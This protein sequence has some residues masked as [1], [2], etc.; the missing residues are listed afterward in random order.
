MK[1]KMTKVSLV[2]TGALLS[3]SV[4]SQDFKKV[5]SEPTKL[6]AAVNSTHEESLPLL[7]ADGEKLYFV[8]TYTS[9]SDGSKKGDQDV[10]VSVREKGKWTEASNDLPN[11][12]NRF[13]NAVV[14]LSK[15]GKKVYLMN[16]YVANDKF[17]SKGISLT[18]YVDGTWE[19]PKAV[20]M[21][22]LKFRGKHYGAYVTPDERAIFFSANIEGNVGEED[23]Y[24][25]LRD[26]DGKWSEIKSIPGNINTEKAE[27]APF[28]SHDGKYLFFASFGHDS[29]GSADLF[30]CERLGKGYANWSNPEPLEGVNT[31][32]F[33]G[34]AHI[35]KSY[36]IIFASNRGKKAD[37]ADL[38]TTKMSMKKI[39]PKPVE[40]EK[41]E[42]EKAVE[43]LKNKFDLQL[44]Y[45]DYD[46]SDITTEDAIVLDAITDIM[47]KFPNISIVLKGHTDVRGSEKYNLKLSEKRVK[48]AEKYLVQKG[49]D[50]T[51]I[52]THAFGES[53]PKF[54]G[55][56]E[57]DHE[58]NRRVEIDIMSSL[59]E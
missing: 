30:V 23:I 15:D 12:N 50:D 57:Q 3:A 25:S 36:N 19:K 29:K 4:F 32:N 55:D 52:F 53:M 24:Y 27:F 2:L 21:P 47:K 44:L 49:I 8:R 34:Y 26:E 38:Y 48:S 28:L 59:T 16:Q 41:T 35:D 37:F 22:E 43:K 31:K 6:S 9:D 17:S 46:K 18:K 54:T 56:T 5:Y 14:G 20:V 10:F 11:I 45:F 40:P 42:E 13:N 33:E 1:L 51:R 58:K 7:S 39:E